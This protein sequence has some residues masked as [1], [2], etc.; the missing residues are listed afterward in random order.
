[1]DASLA[2]F[3]FVVTFDNITDY[4]TNFEFVR[5]VLSMDAI[6]PGSTLLYRRGVYPSLSDFFCLVVITGWGV[7][8]FVVRG[9]AVPRRPPFTFHAAGVQQCHSPGVTPAAL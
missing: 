8:F 9:C 4:D 7:P 1:M 5:H 2:L 6:F 3:A